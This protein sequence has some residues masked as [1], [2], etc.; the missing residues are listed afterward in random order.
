[1]DL[2]GILASR[3]LQAG[4]PESRISIS[5]WCTRCNGSPFFSHRCGDAGRQVGFLGLRS[6]EDI[7]GR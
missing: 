7:G 6:Q 3:G 2:R 1:V 4:V 5:S